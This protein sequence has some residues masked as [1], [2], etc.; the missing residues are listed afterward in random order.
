MIPKNTETGLSGNLSPS[1]IFETSISGLRIFQPIEGWHFSDDSVFLS[2]FVI[3]IIRKIE[4]ETEERNENIERSSNVKFCVDIGAGCG[5][6]TL[7]LAREL[8]NY[9]FFAIDID[10]LMS[11]LSLL[12]FQSNGVRAFSV[13][14]D[15]RFYPFRPESFDIIVS[16][17]PYIPPEEGKKSDKYAIAKWEITLNLRTFAEVSSR[18]VKNRGFV[19][20]VYP[21]YR[22]G[23]VL[24]TFFKFR[25]KP[26]FIRFFHH[27]FDKSADFFA[28][29]CQK[30]VKHK[31][32]VLP[33]FFKK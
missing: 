24:S 6:I 8:K 31:L 9:K 28:L 11:N 19:F 33:P 14:G 17:P 4:K 1:Q 25:L 30:G 3:Q 27:S 16:N 10:K 18:L 15:I 2:E 29:A 32:E 13:C 22:L 21:S 20:V 23:E 26:V 7:L 5:I 12:N